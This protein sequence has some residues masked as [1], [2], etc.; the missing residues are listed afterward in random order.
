VVA[1]WADPKQKPDS[2]EPSRLVGKSIVFKAREITGPRPFACAPAHYKESDFTA[3]T[4][5]QGAFE[6]MRSKDKSVD[7]DKGP[8]SRRWKPDVRST[9][10]SSTPHRRRS[11]STIC[12][13]AEETVARAV[14]RGG[15]PAPCWHRRMST[16][17]KVRLTALYRQRNAEVWAA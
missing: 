16:L 14:M 5:F 3:D 2:A 8:A 7:P 15:A 11:A 1:P 9:F 4:I 17:R 6:E 10:I 13:H 12:V